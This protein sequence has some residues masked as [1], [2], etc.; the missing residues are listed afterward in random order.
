MLFRVYLGRRKPTSKGLLTMV[1]FE[2]L[3]FRGLGFSVLKNP[4]QGRLSGVEVE[5]RAKV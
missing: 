3:G 1:S 4:Q 2:G 5:L